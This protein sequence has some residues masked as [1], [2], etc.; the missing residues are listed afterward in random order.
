MT[1]ASDKSDRAFVPTGSSPQAVS[2]VPASI[3]R[4]DTLIELSRRCWA[5]RGVDDALDVL[6]EIALFEP[7]ENWT[8]IRANSAGT[9]VI[10]TRDDGS[11]ATFRAFDWTMDRNQAAARLALRAHEQ[12]EGL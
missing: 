4:A 7:N 6:I 8:A 2:P 3:P 5:G 9:K 11:E 1:G 12:A 10:Y